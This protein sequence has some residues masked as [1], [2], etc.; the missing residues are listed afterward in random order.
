MRKQSDER[1]ESP[2][3]GEPRYHLQT[4]LTP[5]THVRFTINVLYDADT[6]SARYQVEVTDPNT[7][8]LLAMWARPFHHDATCSDALYE[9]HREAVA[10]ALALEVGEPF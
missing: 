7:K 10:L 2:K 6:R 3:M 4:M 8:E 5:P 1:S 9:V